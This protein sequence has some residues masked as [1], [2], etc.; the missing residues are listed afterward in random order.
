MRVPCRGEFVFYEICDLLVSCFDVESLAKGVR[1][2]ALLA[3]RPEREMT[4]RAIARRGMTNPQSSSVRRC[5]QSEPTRGIGEEYSGKVN[6]MW[7]TESILDF[8]CE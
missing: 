1:A 8:N 3:H 6:L 2:S 4:E 7:N 5:Y